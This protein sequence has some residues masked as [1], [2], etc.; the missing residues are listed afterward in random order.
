MIGIGILGR[1]TIINL[2]L[3]LYLIMR[4]RISSRIESYLRGLVGFLHD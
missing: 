1:T 4:L 2:S 3:S